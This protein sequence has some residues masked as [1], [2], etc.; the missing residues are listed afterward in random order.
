MVAAGKGKR[1]AMGQVGWCLRQGTSLGNQVMLWRRSS[2]ADGGR[3]VQSCQS[4]GA[5]RNPTFQIPF[6]AANFDC[7]YSHDHMWDLAGSLSMAGVHVSPYKVAVTHF[8][9]F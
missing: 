4:A 1:H 5:G 3:E 8:K 2:L 9:A 6:C 7:K